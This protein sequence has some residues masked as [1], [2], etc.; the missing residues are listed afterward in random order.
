[1]KYMRA[2]ANVLLAAKRMARMMH[3][4]RRLPGA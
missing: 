1:M 2:L 3:P 4:N